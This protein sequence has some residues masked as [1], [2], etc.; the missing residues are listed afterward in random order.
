M[1]PMIIS[2]ISAFATIGIV[3]CAQGG[4]ASSEPM[5][6]V[7]AESISDAGPAVGAPIPE[8]F[9]ARDTSGA[10]KHFADLTGENGIVLVFNRSADWCSYCQAQMVDLR[11]IESDLAERGYTL[12]TLSYDSPQTLADFARR[13][14]I[15]Y[16]MLSDEGSAIIDAFDLRDPQY[17]EESFAYGVPRPA[18]FIIGSDGAVQAKMVESDYRVRPENGDI[19]AAVDAL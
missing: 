15:G 5:E 11:S 1:R 9:V 3:A 17:G 7:A 4:E 13:E 12:A 10:E 16:T 19:L 6:Q 18:I 14:D 8:G 2:F